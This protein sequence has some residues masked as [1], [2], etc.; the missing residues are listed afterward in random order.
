MQILY[1]AHNQW[2]RFFDDVDDVV[3]LAIHSL[4]ALNVSLQ[5][6]TTSNWVEGLT[7]L[8]MRESKLHDPN[9]GL[10][11]KWLEHDYEPPRRELLLTSPETRSPWLCRY[12]LDLI[13]GILYY[14]WSEHPKLGT[15]KKS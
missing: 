12:R 3:P 14:S 5:S 13:D 10:I 8:Q 1:R 6:H 15:E 2:S 4:P 9:L 7:I 11:I